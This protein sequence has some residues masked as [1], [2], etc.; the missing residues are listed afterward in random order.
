M[1]DIIKDRIEQIVRHRHVVSWTELD[2]QLEE[3][4]SDQP[5][6]ERMQ[7]LSETIQSN[8][9]KRL[10]YLTPSHATRLE[11]YMPYDFRLML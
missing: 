8:R 3:E 6:S 4:F 10:E 2:T 7:A 11:F 1:N 5:A 9:I